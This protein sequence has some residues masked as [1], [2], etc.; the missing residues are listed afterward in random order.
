MRWATSCAS[1][2]PAI[3][4]RDITPWKQRDVARSVAFGALELRPRADHSRVGAK[5]RLFMAERQQK[6]QIIG[7]RHAELRARMDAV[8]G[9]TTKLRKVHLRLRDQLVTEALGRRRAARG[10]AEVD[11]FLRSDAAAAFKPITGRVE[12][13]AAARRRRSAQWRARIDAYRRGRSGAARE[14]VH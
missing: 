8:N 2:A 13:E 4:A 12:K 1:S 6:G 7:L 14:L 9:T 3:H 5:S 11:A 10:D